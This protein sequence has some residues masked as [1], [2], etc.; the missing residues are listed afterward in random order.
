MFHNDYVLDPY[1]LWRS[2]MDFENDDDD[3]GFEDG[4]RSESM[5]GLPGASTW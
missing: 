5:G 2:R 1:D 3:D 4:Y